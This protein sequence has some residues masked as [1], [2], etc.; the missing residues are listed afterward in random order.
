MSERKD[1]PLNPEMDVHREATRLA[2][3][4]YLKNITREERKTIV[5]EAISEWMTDKWNETNGNIM[6]GLFKAVIVSIAGAIGY[7]VLTTNGW[8]K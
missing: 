1:M 4:E 6:K 7:F 3:L 5:K 2:I 8:H